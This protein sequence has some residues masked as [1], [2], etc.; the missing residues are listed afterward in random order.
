VRMRRHLGYRLSDLWPLCDAFDKCR[1]RYS[2][3]TYLSI[4]CIPPSFY[5]V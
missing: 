3:H 1:G 4:Y 5:G 2:M